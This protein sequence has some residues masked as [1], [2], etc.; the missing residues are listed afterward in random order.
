MSCSTAERWSRC[1]GP[2]VV[3]PAA[4]GSRVTSRKVPKPIAQPPSDKARKRFRTGSAG[5]AAR[6]PAR[7]REPGTAVEA[8]N[9]RVRRPRPRR[10]HGD[11]RGPRG[12]GRDACREAGYL[13]ARNEERHRPGDVAP[14]PATGI[15][16]A[17]RRTESPDARP[18]PG[19]G[20]P[21]ALRRRIAAGPPDRVPAV[22]AQKLDAHLHAPELPQ[23]RGPAR[24]RPARASTS[25][26]DDGRTCGTM[27]RRRRG[28]RRSNS[29][30]LALALPGCSRALARPRSPTGHSWPRRLATGGRHAAGSRS[31]IA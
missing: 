22:Q 26:A 8:R 6:S 18:A 28:R 4:S 11:P 23:G 21:R 15:A 7:L 19:A 24:R 30:V 17:R 25:D 20:R 27:P 13:G 12:D 29:G 16:S 2:P 14:A 9:E 1:I 3:Q 31:A 10:N 5:Q